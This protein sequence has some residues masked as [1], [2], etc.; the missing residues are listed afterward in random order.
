MTLNTYVFTLAARFWESPFILN[1]SQK[2]A[3]AVPADKKT[4]KN[5]AKKPMETTFL[6]FEILFIIILT[7]NTDNEFDNTPFI[8][9]QSNK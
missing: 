8:L 9:K 2:P 7:V 5:A 6:K 4:A 1:Q 3:W